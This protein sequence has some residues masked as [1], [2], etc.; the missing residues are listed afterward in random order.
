[1]RSRK[2]ARRPESQNQPSSVRGERREALAQ[3]GREEARPRAQRGLVAIAVHAHTLH[4]AARGA[5]LEH[6]TVEIGGGEGGHPLLGKRVHA[7]RV[8]GAAG[9]ADEAGARGA[10]AQAERFTGNGE[11]RLHLRTH[12]NEVDEAA[13][14]FDYEGIAFVSAVVAHL[15][16][17]KASANAD[18]GAFM[19][20][21]NRLHD[22]TMRC[23]ARIGS[24]RRARIPLARHLDAPAPSHGDGMFA[25]RLQDSVK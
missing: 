12:G 20:D 24:V 17:E 3:R 2:E 10:R 25:A 18:P 5:A 6:E 23:P 7:G 11:P 13:Q 15:P 1:M 8:V 16:T 19:W 22:P 4:A 9:V 14:G 21:G